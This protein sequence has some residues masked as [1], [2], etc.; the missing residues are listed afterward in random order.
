MIHILLRNRAQI[1]IRDKW[2]FTP[3]IVA[4]HYRNYDLVSFLLQYGA[5][6][7]LCSLDGSTPLHYLIEGIDDYEDSPNIGKLSLQLKAKAE[8]YLDHRK[9][10]E[11]TIL[12]ISKEL[13]EQGMLQNP[14]KLGVTPLYLACLK[15]SE[16][17]VEFL[18]DNLSANDTERANCFELLAS[19]FLFKRWRT[20]THMNKMETYYFLNKAMMIRHSHNPPLWKHRK[21]DSLET[22]LCQFET[23]TL[24]ALAAIKENGYA[25]TTE[26]LLAR[27]RILEVELYNDYLIPFMGTIIDFLI[28]LYVESKV[29]VLLL[30]AFKLQRQ[31]LVPPSSD[32]LKE[33]I[34]WLDNVVRHVVTCCNVRLSV[35]SVILDS[36]E[37]LYKCRNSE[38]AYMTK[39]TYVLLLNVLHCIVTHAFVE[40]VK[41]IKALTKRFLRLT[42]SSMESHLNPTNDAIPCGCRMLTNYHDLPPKLVTGDNVLHIACREIKVP[43]CLRGKLEVSYKA[44]KGLAE[45][46]K[47]LHA[48]GEDV[49]AQNSDG[50]TP[51]QVFVCSTDCII[52]STGAVRSLLLAG[53]NPD[54]RCKSTA[55][56]LHAAMN[57]YARFFRSFRSSDSDLKES[58]SIVELLLKSGAN[59][60][61]RD[62]RGFSPL[63]VLM[64]AVYNPRLVR[65][66]RGQFA[67]KRQ[68]LHKVVR[69]MQ[70]YG[71]SAHAT[72]N[73]GRSVFDM[74][75]DDELLEKM[76]QEIPVTSVHLRLSQLAAAAIRKHRV[77]YHNELP[78]ILIKIVELRD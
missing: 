68:S 33:R 46:L 76:S 10:A 23:Q 34:E 7:N 6:V 31:S 3:L 75:K 38:D 2:G 30:N 17:I 35:F 32:T 24:E 53:A 36:I 25:L 1:N 43:S 5:D 74:C 59:P 71:G 12:Q 61:A 44:R 52:A 66:T 19:S 48:C 11:Q 49:N 28:N 26:L 4:C 15:G 37:E 42:R 73:D 14:N 72:T 63:H 58:N 22:V 55:T 40:N 50:Q 13:L 64:Y 70:R 9:S 60:N 54:L 65:R 29:P 8:S 41:Y 78:T 57:G 16:S 69:T 56:S 39:N 21:P 77:K 27:Q 67:I 18:L 45:L 47:T 51:L 62:S 20:M